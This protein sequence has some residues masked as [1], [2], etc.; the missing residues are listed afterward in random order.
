LLA[1]G[2]SVT[3][4]ELNSQLMVKTFHH[5]Y[6][7]LGSWGMQIG[8]TRLLL[9]A[10]IPQYRPRYVIICSTV[11]D[12]IRPPNASYHNFADA[13]AIMRSH[14]P[15][16]FYFKHFSSIRHIIR[17]KKDAYPIVFDDWGGAQIKADSRNDRHK[18]MPF[19]T[20]STPAAYRSLDSLA[21]M[22][23]SNNIKLIFIETPIRKAEI[24][25]VTARQY[26][27]HFSRCSSIVTR[28]NGT[29]LNYHNPAVFADSLFADNYH[30]KPQGAK[31]FSAMVVQGLKGI[32][33]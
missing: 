29:Y 23:A 18:K 24:D 13:P 9:E 22:L 30:L 27:E 10:F 16:L 26:Q 25:A 19:P 32:V 17:T 3:F 6:Y 20:A 33:Q 7:N 12:F 21:S 28:H 5:S 15:Q 8:D 1:V 11:A 31:L 4:Y 14:L 2:S